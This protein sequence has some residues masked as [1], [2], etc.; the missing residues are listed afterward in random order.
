MKVRNKYHL[1]INAICPVDQSKDTYECVVEKNDIVK[2]EDILD[3]V[4]K[5]TKAPVFQEHLTAQLA[6][7]LRAKVTTIG[8][9]SNVKVIAKAKFPA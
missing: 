7:S 3:V 4:Q 8:V 1:T 6:A 2:V 5:L 9:H